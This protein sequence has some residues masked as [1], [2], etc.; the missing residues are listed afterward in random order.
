MFS[1][2]GREAGGSEQHRRAE[3]SAACALSAVPGLYPELGAQELRPQKDGQQQHLSCICP[4]LSHTL[5]LPCRPASWVCTGP[6][7]T[8]MELPWKWQKS[9]ARPTLS[10]QRSLR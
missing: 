6:L 10:L 4:H 2:W 3:V 8:T 7:W 5:F 9:A 1:A